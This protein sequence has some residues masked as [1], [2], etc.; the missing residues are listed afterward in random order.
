MTRKIIALCIVLIAVSTAFTGCKKDPEP[1]KPD[2][3]DIKKA[4]DDASDAAKEAI[5]D[6]TGLDND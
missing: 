4:V 1:T 6:H 3:D 5:E 2:A